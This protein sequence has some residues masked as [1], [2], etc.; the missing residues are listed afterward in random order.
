MMTLVNDA[1]YFYSIL[2]SYGRN[3]EH[4]RF[5]RG[6]NEMQEAIDAL[7]ETI[8]RLEREKGLLVAVAEAAREYQVAVGT[9]WGGDSDMA[10]LLKLG[11]EFNDARQAA[12][13]GGA[14]GSGD[15][16]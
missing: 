12:I 13:D 2:K 10:H 16:E 4:I 6:L 7:R 9:R 15:D 14:L 5:A 1:D 11:I 8:A 3:N